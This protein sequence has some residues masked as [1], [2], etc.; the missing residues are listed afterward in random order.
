MS[1]WTGYLIDQIGQLNVVP[2]SNLPG[3]RFLRIVFECNVAVLF[4]L[5]GNLSNKT[6]YSQRVW[7][8]YNIELADLVYYP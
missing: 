4:K 3:L 8:G 5:Y 2:N 6:F 1:L 7:I